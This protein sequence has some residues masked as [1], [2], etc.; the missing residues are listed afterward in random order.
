M[1]ISQQAKSSRGRQ[2]EDADIGSLPA[3]VSPRNRRHGEVD[4]GFFAFNYFPNGIGQGVLSEMHFRVIDTIDECFRNGGHYAQAICRGFLKTTI[5][6]VMILRALLYGHRKFL[7]WIGAEDV[8]A[9]ESVDAVC[10]QLEEN[11]ALYE[12]FPEVCHAFRAL[13]GKHQRCKSQTFEGFHTHIH[14]TTG[15]IVFPTIRLTREQS[16]DLGVP[17][18]NISGETGYTVNTSARL[19]S[20][21][22]LSF[23]RGRKH[24]RGDGGI[25]RIDGVV[26]DDFQTDLSAQQPA[27]IN[28]RLQI[29]RKSIL[30][31]GSHTGSLACV[32]NGTV[33]NAGDGMDQLL[34]RQVF[35]KFKSKKI[36]MM[37]SLCTEAAE[38]LWYGPYSDKLTN[39]SPDDDGSKERARADATEFYRANRQVMDEGG[40]PTWLGCFSTDDDEIGAIQHAYNIIILDGRDVFDAE[41]QQTPKRIGEQPDEIK[42]EGIIAKANHMP[43]GMV[44]LWADRVTI[45][46]DVQ[47]NALYWLALATG[48]G[49]S[50]HVLNYGVYPEQVGGGLNY[51][52]V[53]Q[54][55][56]KQYPDAAFEGA[57]TAGVQ[58]LVT[59]H[60]ESTWT[61]EEDH[62]S[63]PVALQGVDSSDNTALIYAAV[64]GVKLTNLL[65]TKGRGVGARV[66]QWVDFPD[67]DGEEL[68]RQYHWL[69]GPTR[70]SGSQRV[71][72]YDTN[73]WKSFV[74]RRLKTKPGD[75][76]CLSFFGEPY[77]HTQLAA[78]I[79][80]ERG[81]IV[82]TSGRSVEEWVLLPGQK[83]NHLLDCLVGAFV[84]AAKA[85]C[86]LAGLDAASNRV[87]RQVVKVP[88]RLMR[89]RQHE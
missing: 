56:R 19:E 75:Q 54:T 36:P 12:D 81:S 89:S 58:A 29:I 62:V 83:D 46:T 5:A 68:N 10:R 23:K 18:T 76:G 39:W 6:E 20:F 38:K 53:K 13:D 25:Q 80:S 33:I 71:L 37:L 1:G 77:E 74:I 60:A 88:T 40:V 48:K 59:R 42:A 51:S 52:S 79:L 17:I 8:I 26:I 11:D 57:L 24:A 35:A 85:G 50:A 45:F 82:T 2:S 78:H 28:R 73:W 69:H 87:E 63:L 21:G 65:P 30:R 86:S 3:V 32:V 55:L 16:A 34:D 15:K 84:L 66:V 9:S 70:G 22:I 27:D 31:S 44:P 72:Q 14:A 41:C 47:D 43:R 61:R 7:G 49:F 67:R 4:P 64:R